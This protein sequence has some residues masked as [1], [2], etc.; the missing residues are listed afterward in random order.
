[1]TPDLFTAAL[2]ARRQRL[3]DLG[4]IESVTPN[5]RYWHRPQGRVTGIGVSESEAFQVLEREEK[6][7]R[8]IFDVVDALTD[9]SRDADAK[10]DQS[11]PH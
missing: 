4:W 5:G 3:R 7:A 10:E 8:A 1:M 9:G 2:E 11:A 6:L